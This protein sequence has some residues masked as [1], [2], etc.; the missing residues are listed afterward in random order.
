MD[1]IIR[2]ARCKRSSKSPIFPC[3]PHLMHMSLEHPARLVHVA[4]DLKDLGF[5]K[6]CE[7]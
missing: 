3:Q 6:G 5:R 1:V 7:N 2:V 4:A